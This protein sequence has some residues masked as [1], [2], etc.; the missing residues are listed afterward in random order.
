MQHIIT[1]IKAFKI[2]AHKYRKRR[3]RFGLRFNLIYT[4]VNF[5]EDFK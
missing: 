3:K 4:L 2:V 1:K 5:I